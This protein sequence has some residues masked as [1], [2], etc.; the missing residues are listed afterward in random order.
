MGAIVIACQTLQNEMLSAVEQTCCDYPILWLE[1]GLHNWPD[2]LR[3]RIQELLDGCGGY[4]T[5]L[6]AMSFCGNCV[7]GLRTHDFQLVIPRCDDCITLLLGSAARRRSLGGT[8]FLTQGWLES[9]LSLWA[10]YDKARKKYGPARAKRV[11]S[12]MLAHYRSLALVDTGG[13]DADAL[14]PRVREMAAELGLES[15]R[16]TGTLDYL[17]ALL[18][19][20]WDENRFLIVPP[21]T[22]ITGEMCRLEEEMP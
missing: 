15:V 17:K 2:K 20:P 19:P 21:H 5:V 3:L 11:F 14:A 4:D 8:Y 9:D 22:R 1:S 7:V 10:E 18:T 16:L 12:T 13:F 6:L